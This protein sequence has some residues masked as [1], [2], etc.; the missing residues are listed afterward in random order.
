MGAAVRLGRA[1]AADEGVGGGGGGWAADGGCRAAARTWTGT[2][3]RAAARGEVSHR[4][5]VARGA[6][7][8]CFVGDGE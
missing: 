7:Y 5:P 6:P 3:G 8:L 1:L 2:H 4:R